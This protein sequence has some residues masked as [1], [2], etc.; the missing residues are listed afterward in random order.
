MAASNTLCLNKQIP[1]N[2]KKRKDDMR[3]EEEIAVS[4]NWSRFIVLKS[5]E[6]GVPMTKIS[7]FVIEK[8]IKSCAGEVK[9]AIKLK[10]GGLMIDESNNL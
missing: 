1:I 2:K 4:D 9:N 10:Y 8:Y 3:Y 7:P 6:D 5:S